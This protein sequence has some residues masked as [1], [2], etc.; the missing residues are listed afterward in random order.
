MWIYNQ[1]TVIFI[2]AR[3]IELQNAIC[4][5]MAILSRPQLEKWPG[6]GVVD[7]WMAGVT[8]AWLKDADMP[9]TAILFQLQCQFNQNKQNNAC[10]FVSNS[11]W[12]RSN[13]T[14]IHTR[15]WVCKVFSVKW[16][17]F[18]FGLI[19]NLLSKYSNFHTN[20]HEFGNSIHLQKVTVFLWP[21]CQFIIKV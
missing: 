10:Y 13:H 2:Q 7:L 14:N 15:K 3:K 21:Q 18:V 17:P 19:V 4:R 12:F 9:M 5:M 11:I 16:W 6:A 1:S 8:R 20:K